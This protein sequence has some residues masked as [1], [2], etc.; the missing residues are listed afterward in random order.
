M[1]YLSTSVFFLLFFSISL[2]S[3]AQNARIRGLVYDEATGEPANYATAQLK[4]TS[5]GAL[6]DDNGSFIIDKIPAGNYI[7]TIT[8]FGYETLTDSISIKG[9][10]L[11]AKRYFLT[12]NS[13][14]LNEVSITVEGQ[15]RIQEIGTSVINVT[16]K[17]MAKMPSIGGQPDFA[18]YLQV[19]PGV[20]STGDQGGQLYVR[21][22]TPIQNMLLL[23]GML[24]YNPFHSIGLFSV[25]DTEIIN[26]ADVYTGGYNAEFGGRISSVMNLKTRD[27]NKKRIAGKLDLNSFGAKILLEGPLVKLKE[28]RSVSLS[29]ILSAKGSFLEQSSKLFYPYIEEE[30]LPFNYLDLYGKLSLSML[31]GTKLNFFTFRFD[32]Q[33]NYPSIATYHWNNWG[34]GTNFII[35]PGNVPT[36]IEGAIS[37]SNYTSSIGDKNY[38]YSV[39]P[40]DSTISK[41]SSLSGFTINLAFNYYIQ[42]N[43]LKI[44]FEANGF[45]ADYTYTAANGT[46]M[47]VNDYTTDIGLF[48][49]YKYN[50]RDKLII[51]PGFRL[52]YFASLS[53]SSPEPRLSMKYNITKKIRLKMAAGLYSQNFVAITSDR[54]VVSLFTGFLSSPNRLPSTFDGKDMKNTLQ[55]AQHVVLGLELDLI[56]YTTVNIEG[57]YKNFSQLT[58]TNR[59]K[60]FENENDYIWEKGNAYGGDLTVKFEYKNLYLWGVYSL[61]WVNRY[62]GTVTYSPHFDRR[63]NLNIMA[64]YAF[65]KKARKSWQVDLRWNYGSGFPYTQTQVAYPHIT[66]DGLISG[67]FVTENESMYLLLDELNKGKLPDYHRLDFSIKKKFFIGERNTIELNASITNLYNYDNIFYVDRSS[68]SIIYQLPLLYS[69]GV[70]WSF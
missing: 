55:K 19:L 22:G 50:F 7:L 47:N 56:K 4:G 12:T 63:H 66:G 20:V 42:K 37:Y 11:V 23:D 3:F 49:K 59:Y 61:G 24:I 62:D 6:T 1:K 13:T 28:D 26:S 29:Y 41:L 58:V 54:D 21:G 40:T 2:V 64:S 8:L 69:F 45:Q 5:M 14:K 31:N 67:D 52:Q 68:G 30:T 39:D 46:A 27:G 57:Y 10:E 33:V 25:F 9:N 65:G 36:T 17:D 15:R 38:S 35:V 70:N 32:D 51:E 60:L 44:G 43:Q 53:C 48:A 18:Q 16:P 34:V